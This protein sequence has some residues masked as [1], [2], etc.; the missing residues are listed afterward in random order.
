MHV[1]LVVYS[2]L[3]LSAI[4]TYKQRNTLFFFLAGVFLV[5]F[6]GFRYETGCDY[7]GYLHRWNNYV[8]PT[9]LAHLLQGEEAGFSFLMGSVRDLGLDYTWFNVAVSVILVFCYV[10][11]ASAHPFGPLILALLFPIIV[12]QLGMSG[13]RQALAGGFLMLAF[14]AFARQE[15]IWTAFW[16]L[17]GMQFHTSVIMFLPIAFLAGRQLNT[18]TL[19]G[20]L[21]VVGPVAAL[22]LADRFDTYESRYIQSDVTSAGAIFRYALV[23]LPI[24]FFLL[25]KDKVRNEF[26]EVFQLLKLGVLVIVSLAPLTILSSIALHRLTFYIMP[27][28]IL[29]CIYVGAILS[30]KPTQGHWF[31][32]IAYGT[33]SLVWFSTSRHAQYCYLPYENTWFFGF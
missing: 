21:S 12:I 25:Y 3:V 22:L 29:L 4:G 8:P 30:K 33:Y 26:P 6:M 2:S 27:L 28:S 1:Y 23:F 20:A 13:V 9:S 10:R 19:A 15:R 32:A 11:F 14:N 16:I 5:W 7:Y 17:V 31:A 18:V 24:P